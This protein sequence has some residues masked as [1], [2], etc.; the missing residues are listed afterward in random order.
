M[1]SKVESDVVAA[2]G[3]PCLLRNRVVS[4]CTI[5]KSFD[6]E[7]G[8]PNKRI[9]DHN[10]AVRITIDEELDGLVYQADGTPIGNQVDTDRR[11]WSIISIKRGSEGSPEDDESAQDL[12]HRYAKQIVGAVSAAGYYEPAYLAAPNPFKIPNTFEA[13]SQIGPVQDRIRDMRIA[14]IGLGGTG[15]Y[16]LDLIAKTPVAEIHLLDADELDWH[17]LM[18]APGAP[19]DEEIAEIGDIKSQATE[20][21]PK[22]AYYHSKYAP[23]SGMA[24][25]HTPFRVDSQSTFAEFLSTQPIDFVFVCIDQNPDSDTPATGS[26][27]QRAF[28]S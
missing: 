27:L 16:V 25:A 24:S 7:N 3:V 4:T 21:L 10:H 26:R 23:L 19:T 5:E 8:K 2:V 11:S 13:R 17:N 18:R 6:P 28:R 1:R 14:I 12:V 20:P 22:V 15:S 9:G